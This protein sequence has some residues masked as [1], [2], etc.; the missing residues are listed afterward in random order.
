MGSLSVLTIDDNDSIRLSI[1]SFLDD[2]GYNVFEASCGQDGIDIIE[3][4]VIDV[5][6]TDTHMP[7]LSGIDVLNYVKEHCPDTPIIVISGA[8][9]IRFVVE[10]LRAGAWDYI[11]K[12][13]EDLDFLTYS[14]D[15]VVKRVN[16]IKE[17]RDKTEELKH[18]NIELSESLEMLKSTQAQLVESEK[19]ASLGYMVN[20][21]AH[22]MNTPLGVCMTSTS[23]LKE[24]S[25][26]IEKLSVNNTM[27][28][29]DLKAFI[30]NSKELS[31]I[32]YN[33]LQTINSL[34]T[35]F[36]QLSM[37]PGELDK[38]K[39][40]LNETIT[41]L[42][43]IV[44]SSYPNIDVNIKVLGDELEIFSY[45]EVISRVIV[46]LGENAIIH[47]FSGKSSGSIAVKLEYINERVYIILKNSG[48]PIPLEIIDKIFDPFFTVNKK[49]GSGLG[50]S[51]VHN[52]VTFTLNGTVRCENMDDGVS[53]LI[54]FPA[55][56]N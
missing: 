54:E 53:Y 2:L 33:S 29:S 16:L 27:K 35:N 47:G 15:Q 45:P 49:S 13:I 6:L 12:P 20:G 44:S 46:N 43:M 42:L 24:Q 11:I 56:K 4:E 19:M 23:Y 17:N 8:G 21:V 22:E 31:E 32:L 18:K 40:N 50:L 7:G 36:K 10:A 41:S 55:E 25:D 1:S 34:I 38:R 37:N 5:V 30:N 51:I 9:E 39:F 14:I 52:L 26:R 48:K 3:K 28:R